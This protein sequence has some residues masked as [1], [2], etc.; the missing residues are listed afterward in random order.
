MRDASELRVQEVDAASWRQDRVASPLPGAVALT[1]LLALAST[2][3]LHPEPSGNLRARMGGEAQVSQGGDS[4]LPCT[5][6]HVAAARTP[7]ISIR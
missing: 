3:R 1:E 2:E 4:V 5:G 7:A 6:V